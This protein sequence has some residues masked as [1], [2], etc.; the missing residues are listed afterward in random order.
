MFTGRSVGVNMSGGQIFL[1]S[2]SFVSS[3]NTRPANA[4]ILSDHVHRTWRGGEAYLP[5]TIKAKD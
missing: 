5:A 4:Q 3:A 2:G 1:I